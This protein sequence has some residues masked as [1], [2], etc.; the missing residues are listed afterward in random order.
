M[1][2]NVETERYNITFNPNNIKEDKN[3]I[4]RVLKNFQKWSEY[5]YNWKTY[6][7]FSRK[8][9][10]NVETVFIRNERLDTLKQEDEEIAK[11]LKNIKMFKVETETK[12]ELRGL[13]VQTA[14][15]RNLPEAQAYIRALDESSLQIITE[16]YLKNYKDLRKNLPRKRCNKVCRRELD[17][18]LSD[19]ID[20]LNDIKK[21]LKKHKYKN[22]LDTLK[23]RM[24]QLIYYFP[25]YE[26]V[27]QTLALW[28]STSDIPRIIDSISDAK[29]ARKYEQKSANHQQEMNEILAETTVLSQQN[30]RWEWTEE[31]LEAAINWEAAPVQIYQATDR[32]VYTP[33][34]N[35]CRQNTLSWTRCCNQKSFNRR[36]GE[37]FSNML[38]Q[39]FPKAMNK[40]PRQKEAW[41]NIW[42]IIA[43]W[44]AIF[45]WIKAITSLKKGADWKRNWWAALA[46][47][48]WTLWILNF[49]KIANTIQ[50]AFNR[51]P[52]E[53]SRAVTDLFSMYWFSNSEATDIAH[54][55]IWAPIATMSALHFIP[56]YQLEQQQILQNKDGQIT[57]NYNNYEQYIK[58]LGFNDQQQ[59][60]LLGYWKVL[61]DNDK[62]VVGL[63]LWTF[64]IWTMED[65]HSIY[66]WDTTKTLWQ[67][68]QVQQWW[69]NCVERISSGVNSEL[70]N[71]G[72]R[73]KS[74]AAL[75][76]IVR[77]Y[78]VEKN[79]TK[80]KDLILR[81]MRNWLLEVSGSDRN[82]NVEEMINKHPTEL[83]LEEMTMEWFTN[84][85]WTPIRFTSYWDL[86]DT[87][88]LTE[89][90]KENFNRPAVTENPFHIDEIKWRIEFDDTEWYEVW[91]N[92]TDVVKNRTLKSTSTILKNNKQNYVDYLNRRRRE[93]QRINIDAT[94][95]P[96]AS[97]LW[98][99]FYTN[100]KEIED[101]DNWLKKI[102]LDSAIHIAGSGDSKP[103][104]ITTVSRNLEFKGFNKTYTIE[105]NL[106]QFPT[107]KKN[108]QKLLDYLN[109]EN[110]G[111]YL[112]YNRQ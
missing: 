4:Q 71:H 14:T 90:I 6:L 97:Q 87:V 64:G 5:T 32:Y 84:S 49:D 108:E 82:Y 25:H 7:S 77:E 88:H 85:W 93:N 79:N 3:E 109:N 55:Y 13:E 68:T 19:N 52:A 91:K 43:V 20:S 40:D 53:K 73:A 34:S 103:F 58:T 42:S 66:N 111:M 9:W 95:Y 28:W 104:R 18:I 61:K 2:N 112:P 21:E 78:N 24:W 35:G 62:N 36:F 102:K 47:G 8:V 106:S 57:F 48:A 44:W 54:M 107:L 86:F 45:M 10:S 67:T 46:W 41:T 75:D 94:K 29:D 98:I 17:N 72:L 96:M 81:W 60:E 89:W 27:R 51:H 100:E 76:Q 110:N 30:R 12:S 69:N 38:E 65:L 1:A 99:N 50:D 33:T 11:A 37:R 56:V 22:G 63:G 26:Q 59:Q 74:P 101:I 15:Y 105:N 70:F 31:A 16:Q 80:I 83:N 39:I 92:E 23:A